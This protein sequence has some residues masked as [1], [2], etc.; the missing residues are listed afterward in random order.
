MGR[1]PNEKGRL[2]MQKKKAAKAA[3][4]KASGYGEGERG[5]TVPYF[6]R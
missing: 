2:P 3:K 6:L 4:T 1:G 5:G